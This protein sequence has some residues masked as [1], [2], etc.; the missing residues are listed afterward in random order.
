MS[1]PEFHPDQKRFLLDP[2]T[3]EIKEK[4]KDI[5]TIKKAVKD[6]TNPAILYS[7]GLR[8]K[9]LQSQVKQ[10]K[11]DLVQTKELIHAGRQILID[12]MKG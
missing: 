9:K 1:E 2:I 4:Q 7:R 12:F 10:R 5:K 11:A 6:E 3:S 8:I